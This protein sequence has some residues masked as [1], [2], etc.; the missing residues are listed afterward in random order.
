MFYTKDIRDDGRVQVE[1][2]RK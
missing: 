2:S 1:A